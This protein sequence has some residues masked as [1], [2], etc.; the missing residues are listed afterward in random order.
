MN[1]YLLNCPPNSAPY[2]NLE[3]AITEAFEIS[4][5]IKEVSIENFPNTNNK[6]R[7]II[8]NELELDS[9]EKYDNLKK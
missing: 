4:K 3:D 6:K 7:L 9:L 8:I 1:N 5:N 2:E